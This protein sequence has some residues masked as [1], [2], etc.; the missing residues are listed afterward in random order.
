VKKEERKMLF[1]SQED[2]EKYSIAQKF[3]FTRIIL[4]KHVFTVLKKTNLFLHFKKLFFNKGT[5]N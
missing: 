4:R 1:Y 3:S 5:D 2:G